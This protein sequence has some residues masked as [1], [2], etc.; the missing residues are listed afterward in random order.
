MGPGALFAVGNH[1]VPTWIG[2][3]NAHS[4][5]LMFAAR[6]LIWGR[7]K[8]GNKKASKR[9]SAR[10]VVGFLAALGLLVMSSGVALMVTSTSADAAANQKVVVCKYVSTP[11][12]HLDHIV[13]VS[14]NTLPAAF[15][16]DFPFEW[17][18]AHGQSLAGSIAVRYA[19][20]GEQ[21]KDVP[22]SDCPQS[23]TESTPTTAVVSFQDPTCDNGNT[24]DYSA[25]GEG[26]DFA[27]DGTVAPGESVTVTATAQDGFELQGDSKFSHEFS[28]AEDCSSVSPPATPPVVSPPKVHHTKH[29][30]TVTPTVVHAGLTGATVQ[31]M[32]GEQG[33]ALMFAG[34][35][36]MVAAG[37]LG[38]RLRGVASRI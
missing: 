14:D 6:Q 10:S 1:A 22:L 8:M 31:D 33:L 12:G 19:N 34:M 3:G 30:T 25:T 15:D 9:A 16:G 11:G 20:P 38:L 28:A 2:G 5:A 32:R 18:D 17:T 23:G 4:G 27:L 36:M 24:A 21:A 35:L 13:V 7:T 29:T 26:I 37:G